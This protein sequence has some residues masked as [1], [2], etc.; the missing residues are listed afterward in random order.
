MRL[1]DVNG[2]V[3]NVDVR[4]SKHPLRAKSKS[5]LQKQV[6]LA[7][8]ELIINE[9]ILEEFPVPGSRMSVDFFVPKRQTVI[10]V[11]GPAHY[12]H[13]PIFHGDKKVSNKFAGQVKRDIKKEQWAEINGFRFITIDKEEDM[14]KLNTI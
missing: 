13:V 9:P 11:N 3:V 7:L 1:L 6:G 12:T 10:E 14:V 2:N 5:Y 4:E 8:K